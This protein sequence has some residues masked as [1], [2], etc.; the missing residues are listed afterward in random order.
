MGSIPGSGNPP[1]EGNGNP[2]QNSCLGNPMDRGAW[3]ATV[4]GVAKR[5]RHSWSVILSLLKVSESHTH[6]LAGWFHLGV[7]KAHWIQHVHGGFC[8]VHP[9]SSSCAPPLWRWW[10]KP[11][12]TPF[13]LSPRTIPPPPPLPVTKSCWVYLKAHELVPPFSSCGHCPGSNLHGLSPSLLKYPHIWSPCLQPCHLPDWNVWK[14]RTEYAIPSFS[15]HTE[16]GPKPKNHSK[17]SPILHHFSN[18]PSLVLILSA[19]VVKTI[20]L[21]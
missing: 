3:R 1:R 2:L 15:P 6:L 20:V 21:T 12:L 14:M 16:A 17:N 5:V 8:M 7:G 18:L 13:S 9:R 19:R 10:P 4:H 11:S